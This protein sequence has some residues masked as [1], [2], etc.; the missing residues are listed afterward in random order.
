MTV[1][2]IIA[3]LIQIAKPRESMPDQQNGGGSM[4]DRILVPLDG[5][6]L[7]RAIL[8]RVQAMAAAHGSEVVLLQVLPESGVLPKTAAKERQ[9]AEDYL[10]EVEQALLKEGVKA[11]HTIR[12]GSDVAA[13]IA[14]YAEVNDIDLIAMST[15]GRGGISRWVLGSVASKVLRGTTKPILLV[16]SPGATVK[17]A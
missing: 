3:Y 12:H 8:P 16:R 7:A 17:E 14:D 4:Y 5:S 11:V 1:Q 13:E 9:E 15:H 6:D 2:F 10:M